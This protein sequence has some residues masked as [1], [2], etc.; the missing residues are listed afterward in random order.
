MLSKKVSLYI[1]FLVVL[2]VASFE[3]HLRTWKW[4]IEFLFV[5]IYTYGHV[6]D[7]LAKMLISAFLFRN[8]LR[9]PERS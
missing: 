8:S 5:Y 6:S 9:V 7:S 1:H 2:T 3:E 4:K